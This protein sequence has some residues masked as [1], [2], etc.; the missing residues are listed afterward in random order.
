M[1]VPLAVV[2]ELRVRRGRR[3]LDDPGFLVDVRG[4]DR[5]AGVEVADDPLHAVGDEL[6]RDRDALLRIRDVVADD[7]LDLLAVDAAGGVDVLGRLLGAVL[8]LGAERRV[9][10]G[11]RPA[12][13]DLDLRVGRAR[14]SKTETERNA[15]QQHFLHEVTPLGGFLSG[16]GFP[17][18]PGPRAAGQPAVGGY[19]AFFGPKVTPDLV[20]QVAWRSSGLIGPA[21]G[22]NLFPPGQRAR[23]ARRA[24]GTA[25]SS[26]APACSGSR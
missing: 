17:V 6:V 24:S 25:S 13:A 2:G 14:E 26:G 10:P 19:L 15:G 20:T 8:E 18:A 12:D 1:R 16:P 3:D 5:H 22:L 4:R 21:S 23:C 9:R 7:D 11:D